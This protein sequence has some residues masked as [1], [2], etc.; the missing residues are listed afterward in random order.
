MER[1]RLDTEDQRTI[2]LL[3]KR[4]RER[5]AVLRRARILLLAHKGYSRAQIHEVT[6]AST[7]TVGRTKR[8]YR[9]QGLFAAIYDAERPGRPK[10]MDAKTKA[11]VIA[12]A[13]SKPP[14][15]HSRWTYQLIATHA[16]LDKRISGESVR[17]MMK[18][19]GLKP[20]REKNVVHTET[21]G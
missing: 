8:W 7:S 9:E 20:W 3:L 2:R 12:T 10:K 18:A 6:E 14:E 19:D 21:H 13:C 1:F 5:A 16:P 11:I 17:L 15:G 4:G